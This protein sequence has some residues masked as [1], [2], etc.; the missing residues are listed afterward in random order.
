MTR[1]GG[2]ES[3]LS[4]TKLRLV[5]GV[6]LVVLLWRGGAAV[7]NG[8]EEIPA[9]FP[10]VKRA[11]TLSPEEKIEERLAY[12]EPIFGWEQ[13]ELIDLYHFLEEATKAPGAT[14]IA[15]GRKGDD[16]RGGMLPISML[17]FPVPFIEYREVPAEA[18]ANPDATDENA[19]IVDF[20]V[21]D[22]RLLAP[23][24][25]L[26]RDSASYSLWRGRKKVE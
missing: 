10:Q 8:V 7:V 1:E 5:G 24:L 11:V 26:V 3:T 9:S 25:D 16:K 15:F 12:W 13:G 22:P 19:W 18:L 17:L 2:T 20:D 21:V 4:K 6:L 14:V 23:Q